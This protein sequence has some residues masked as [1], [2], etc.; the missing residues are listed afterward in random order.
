MTHSQRFALV[1]LLLLCVPLLHPQEAPITSIQ[2]S[3][4]G[5]MLN[6]IKDDIKHD[7]YDPKFHGVDLD[8]QFKQA[9]EYLKTS[10]TYNQGIGI[11]AWALK[12]FNDSHLYLIPPRRPVK[13][14][15][16]YELQMIGS[17]C[18][19]TAIEP[20]AEAEKAGLKVGDKIVS[21]DGLIFDRNSFW[22]VNYLTR[23][24]RPQSADQ[25]VVQADTGALT[26]LSIAAK[27]KDE[28]HYV[29]FGMEYSDLVREAQTRRRRLNPKAY[30]LAESVI[31][32]K[33]HTFLA[34][35]KL[36]DDMLNESA[37][38][39]AFIL[40]LRQNGGGAEL[41][42]L[43]LLGGMFDHDVNVG[44]RLTRTGRKPLVAKTHGGSPYKGKVIVLVD[45]RSASASE[46][47]ARV[48][49][50]QKRGIVI[51]DHTA[52]SVMEAR[53]HWH[54]FGRSHDLY[55]TSISSADLEMS[56]GQSL[57]RVGV[58]PD[59]VLLPTADDLAKGRDPVMAHAVKLAGAE[60]SPAAAG[61]LFP[62]EWA[63]D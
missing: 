46:I 20:G 61:K 28:Q 45:Q 47:L 31:I 8:A 21:M 29:K 15:Y 49:Q 16:S 3:Y 19:A 23:I 48:M 42:L 56:D 6:E 7:Y 35:E 44:E 38:Y 52:G 10:A 22:E 50:L 58:A 63:D 18:Y 43:R 33:M 4:I 27:V 26:K 62:V 55:A 24:L 40:D 53:F 39:P 36:M 25:M 51:G 60:M 34:D 5:V 13:I 9:G 12:P 2:R 11:V 14:T 17:S 59:E 30:T 1:V 54:P 37:K 32:W 41:A 57:E